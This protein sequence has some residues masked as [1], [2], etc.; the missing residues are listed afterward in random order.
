MPPN[1]DLDGMTITINGT[2]YSNIS[3]DNASLSLS[4][5]ITQDMFEEIRMVSCLRECSGFGDC[6]TGKYLRSQII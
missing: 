3:V 6:T 5:V 1:E 2:S 4:S